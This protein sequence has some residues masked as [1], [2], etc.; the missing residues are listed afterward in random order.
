[1]NVLAG[2]FLSIVSHGV[3]VLCD[4]ELALGCPHLG[5]VGDGECLAEGHLNHKFI[6]AS[7]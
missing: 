1:M 3:C 5:H 4:Q 6:C 2:H 7:F